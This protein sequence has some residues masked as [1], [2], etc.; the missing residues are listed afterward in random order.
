MEEK[1]TSKLME[2][3]KHIKFL[4]HNMQ[5]LQQVQIQVMHLE[6]QKVS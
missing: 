6:Q 5:L 2:I 4:N 1:S 3:L